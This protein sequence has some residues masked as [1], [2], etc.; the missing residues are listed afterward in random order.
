MKK[1]YYKEDNYTTED[2]LEKAIYYYLISYKIENIEMNW[3]KITIKCKKK[4][5][6]A[7]DNIMND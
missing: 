5:E 2:K 4:D 6:K 1:T 7:I 3:L